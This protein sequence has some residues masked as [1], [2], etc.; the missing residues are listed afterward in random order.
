MELQHIACAGCRYGIPI[1]IDA[2]MIAAA[3]PRASR[4]WCD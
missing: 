3:A 1:A 2:S 4:I